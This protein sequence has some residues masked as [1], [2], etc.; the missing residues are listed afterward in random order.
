LIFSFAKVPTDDDDDDNNDT[1]GTNIK[2]VGVDEKR[3][4]TLPSNRDV[5]SKFNQ[6]EKKQSNCE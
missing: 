5:A 6:L 1:T 2:M 3:T 4:R